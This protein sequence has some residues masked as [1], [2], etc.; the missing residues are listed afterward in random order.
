MQAEDHSEDR[1]AILQFLHIL[2]IRIRED[3][4]NFVHELLIVAEVLSNEHRML[5]VDS[6]VIENQIV[7]QVH[8][9]L[10]QAHIEVLI[11]AAVA[12]ES[13]KKFEALLVFNKPALALEVVSF[14]P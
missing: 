9:L 1:V 5:F 14:Y 3:R 8:D 11:C 6:I 4:P 12:Q 2:E 13:G 7:Q 10:L